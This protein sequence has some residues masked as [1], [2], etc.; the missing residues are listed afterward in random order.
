MP[1]T[2]NT[3][4]G[5]SATEYSTLE[6]SVHIT[7]TSSKPASHIS[8]ENYNRVL[9]NI[10]VDK[11]DFSGGLLEEETSQAVL[12]G[13]AWKPN[14]V[15]LQSLTRPRTSAWLHQFPRLHIR[16]KKGADINQRHIMIRVRQ[17]SGGVGQ[18]P[19]QE[20]PKNL[21]VHPDSY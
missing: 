2:T 21:E 3:F 19:D 10:P 18:N 15:L 11:R 20:R 8:S 17:P 6:G 16:H 7:G 12:M 4:G 9:P 13:R 14:Q 1:G 5:T